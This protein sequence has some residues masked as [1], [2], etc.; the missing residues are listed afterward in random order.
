MLRW[1]TV[2]SLTALLAACDAGTPPP[3]GVGDKPKEDR[4]KTVFDDQIKA[5]DKAKGVEQQEMDQKQKLDD[6][7]EN[8]AH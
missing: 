1:I 3:P 6:Q 7:I 4:T 2:V 8:D 5:L